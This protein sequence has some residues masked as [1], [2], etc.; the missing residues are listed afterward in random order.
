MDLKAFEYVSS[1]VKNGNISKAA[2][3]LHISQPALSQYIIKLEDSLGAKLFIRSKD[4]IRLTSAGEMFLSDGNEILTM[5]ANMRRRIE[6]TKG[7][8]ITYIRLGISQFYSKF[9]LPLILPEFL[10]QNPNVR[11][12]ITEDLNSELENKLLAGELDFCLIPLYHRRRQ[13]EYRILHQEEIYA[14]L[15]KFSHLNTFA[16]TKDHGS[17]IDLESLRNAPFIML[18]SSQ[19]FYK[20]SMELCEASGFT[21]NVICEVLNWDTISYLI[22]EGLGVGFVPDLI[23]LSTVY[24]ANASYYKILFPRPVVRPYALVSR[25]PSAVK[26]GPGTDET[27]IK[28]FR[29][30]VTERVNLQRMLQSISY[31]EIR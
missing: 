17:Y 15:P 28:Q 16:V 25:R 1:I 6:G 4:R 26:T 2:E 24:S 30:F 19:G 31:E 3:E 18:H 12:K 27:V 9:Y 14:A 29:D 5:Y 21:P 23:A 7:T 13:L 22:R 10:E 8:G 20:L 11:F